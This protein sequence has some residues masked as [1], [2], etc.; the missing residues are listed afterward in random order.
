MLQLGMVPLAILVVMESLLKPPDITI[1]RTAP[2]LFLGALVAMC[3]ASSLW[4][5]DPIDAL[6]TAVKLAGILLVCMTIVNASVAVRRRSVII[7]AVSAVILAA[8]V[9]SFRLMPALELGFWFS[10]AASITV[11]P[12][13]LAPVRA[14]TLRVNALSAEKAGGVFSN[15]NA[16][17]LFF[18]VALFLTLA[19]TTRLFLR[20]LLAIPLAVAVVATGSKAGL[21]ALVITGT[22]WVLWNLRR[23]I[24][25]G[26]AAI[27]IAGSSVAFALFVSLV[28][29]QDLLPATDIALRSR[30][31]VWRV[32]LP[33]LLEHPVLG[34]GFGGWDEWLRS[35]HLQEGLQDVF[36]LH[37]LFLIGWSWGGALAAIIVAGFLLSAIISAWRR[38]PHPSFDDPSRE[39]ALTLLF[40][41]LLIQS[42]FTNAAVTNIAIGFP[43]GIGLGLAASSPLKL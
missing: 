33:V 16:A 34:L 39:L 10:P 32:A 6:K 40:T 14:G 1:P 12:D 29:S 5:P 7:F 20:L 30:T 35:V 11:D 41:W 23:G 15:A 2:V 9:I 26:W 42:M 36:P 13:V 8:M 28:I 27:F 3:L 19:I 37:N 31:S 17:S 4:S 21:G 18:G 43:V 22:A 38:A 25:L 24:S